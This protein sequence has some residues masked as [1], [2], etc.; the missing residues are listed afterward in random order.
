MMKRLFFAFFAL[1][2]ISNIAMS[3]DTL[4]IEILGIRND[5]NVIMLQLFNENEE[6][7]RQEM[8][9]IVEKKCTIIIE[10]LKPGKYAVRYFHDENG[11]G[12]LDTNNLGIP[13][14]GYGFSNDAYG[15]FGPKPFNEW[16]FEFNASK[17]I[18]LKINY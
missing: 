9:I 7:I 5:E 1:I 2:M 14:E 3:Q 12:A 8:S 13:T 16:L 18:I 10:D 11:N 17:K 6:V 4:R 15:M